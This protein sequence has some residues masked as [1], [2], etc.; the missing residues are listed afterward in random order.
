[1]D[2]SEI[3]EVAQPSDAPSWL[4]FLDERIE[5]E[6]DG[7]FSESPS[8]EIVRDLLVASEDDDTAVSQAVTKFYD[9]YK[10]EAGRQSKMP[11]HGAGYYLNTISLIAFE[12]APKVWYA[13]WRHDR[14]TEFLIAIKDGAAKEFDEEDPQ[15]VWIGWGLQAAASESWN[16][17]HVDTYTAKNSQEPEDVWAGEWFSSCALLAKLFRGG[18]L[19]NDGQHWI[20]KDL[21]R[22]FEVCTS[23]DIKTDA[24]RQA[25]V[26][27]A[28]NHILLA[29]EVFVKGAKNPL[30]KWK[31]EL[32]ATKWKLWASKIKEVAET[33]DETARWDLKDRAQKAYEKMVELYPEAFSSD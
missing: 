13:S 23:G 14:I 9:L 16:A 31:F 10:A 8:Y 32:N 25:Q 21:E 12:V 22:T 5:E 33:V 6:R 2:N 20:T 28:I 18:C 26:L 27:A 4:K 1:M 19:D 17:G 7:L 29:G 30:P 3:T 24:G 11:D 15:F